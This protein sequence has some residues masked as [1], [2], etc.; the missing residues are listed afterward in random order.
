MYWLKRFQYFKALLFPIGL[1]VALL[2]VGVSGYMIIEDYSFFDAFYMTVITVGTVGYMEVQPLSVAGRIFTSVII[3]IN[4]GAFTFFVTYLTRY[5]L[6]GEFIR[7]YK[8]MKMDNAI[9]QLRNHVIVCGFGR[10]GTESAQVLFNNN[11]PFVV[12]EEKNALPDDLP[13]A[14]KYFMKGDATKDETLKEAGIDHARAIIATMPIDADNLFMV[15]TARQLNP[16][17]TIISRA[18]QDS[19]VNKLKIAGANNVIMPDKIG[20]AQMATLVLNPDVQEMISLMASKSNDQF[21]LVEIV[22]TKNISLAD[23]NLWAT[24]HCTLLAVK[25]GNE[26]ILNPP[27]GYVIRGGERLILMG[28]EEQLQEAKKMV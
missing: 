16:N 18:S 14:V 19:S 20:G 15:L 2:L 17:I 25:N 6:D 5:L 27:P 3:L 28:S 12:V 7:T 1:F 10:N 11:I 13:F 9:L 21:R 4:I 8:Q 23:L 24:T 22:A 26:Y